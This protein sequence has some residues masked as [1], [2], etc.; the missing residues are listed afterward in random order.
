R[1]IEVIE[2]YDFEPHYI[3][4]EYNKVADALSRRPDF[5][6]ALITEFGLADDVT[7]SMVEAYRENRFMSEI[8]CKLEVKDKATSAEFELVNGV[9]FLEKAGNRRLPGQSLTMDFMDTLFTSKSGMRHIFVIVDR[10]SKYARLVAMSETA[11][12]EHVIKLFKENWVRDFGLP[13]SIVSDRDV[14]FTSELWKAAAAEQ[15]TQLQMTSGNHPEANGQ[16]E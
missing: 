11:K 13:K 12:T 3:K 1:W 10:F 6:G 9:L 15:G 16:A 4:G 8:I 5:S 14:R 2:Q 7:Q